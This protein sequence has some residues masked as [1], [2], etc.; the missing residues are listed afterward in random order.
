MTIENTIFLHGLLAAS[1]G[2][3][4]EEHRMGQWKNPTRPA[5]S[6]SPAQY[7]RMDML[8]PHVNPYMIAFVT[9]RPLA[10][11]TDSCVSLAVGSLGC[12]T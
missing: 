7:A 10:N 1:A 9:R 6:S 5:E 2:K 3:V 11:S 4:K 12:N 8:R